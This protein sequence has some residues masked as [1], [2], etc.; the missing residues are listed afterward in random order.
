M[1]SRAPKGLVYF[2][3]SLTPIRTVFYSIAQL[4]FHRT[5]I[6]STGSYATFFSVKFATSGFD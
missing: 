6:Y 2:A 5:D 3:P 1:I 4:L